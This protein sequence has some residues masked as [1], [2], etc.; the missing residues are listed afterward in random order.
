MGLPPASGLKVLQF[1][2]SLGDF[3]VGNLSLDNLEWFCVFNV[4]TYR[5]PTLPWHHGSFMTH[6]RSDK[7][8]GLGM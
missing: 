6:G 3:F 5:V 7:G 4:N 2:F 8:G 1:E